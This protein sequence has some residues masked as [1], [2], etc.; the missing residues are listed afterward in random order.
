MTKALLEGFCL[1]CPF[2]NLRNQI[3]ASFANNQNNQNKLANRGFFV[4][5]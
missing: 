1:I 4:F 3:K 2:M 5:L